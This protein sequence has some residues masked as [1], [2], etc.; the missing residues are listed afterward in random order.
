MSQRA[1][2]VVDDDADCREA[3]AD[4]LYDAGYTVLMAREGRAALELL[5]AIEQIPDLMLLDIMMPEL[6]GYEVLAELT[7]NARLAQVP[8]V[9]LSASHR[10]GAAMPN[11]RGFLQKPV[12][13][14]TLL[15]VVAECV[16]ASAPQAACLQPSAPFDTQDKTP[17]D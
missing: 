10:Q 4:V 14:D 13:V 6:D 3:L 15:D 7:K 5:Q 16:G 1:V 17:I 2:L 8:T 9:L 11:V 12:D